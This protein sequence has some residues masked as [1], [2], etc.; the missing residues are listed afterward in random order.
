LQETVPATLTQDHAYGFAANMLMKEER[1]PEDVIEA[2][3]QQGYDEPTAT[4]VVEDLHRQI[5]T[6]KKDKA[7][8]DVLYG[9][10]WLVGGT[11]LTMSN[12]GFIFWGA[13][14]FGG[15]QLIRGLSNL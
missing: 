15:I 1:V 14:I 4:Y 8:K 12:I 5:T 6:L 13:I 2:L 9:G 11:I 10:L 7:K 3:V